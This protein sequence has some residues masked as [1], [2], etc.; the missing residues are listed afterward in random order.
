MKMSIA[1]PVNDPALQWLLGKDNLLLGCHIVLPIPL[2]N[3][4]W[5][6]VL[7]V[8]YVYRWYTYLIRIKYLG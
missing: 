7:Y 8:D 3:V 2:K 5:Y 4:Y 6:T 1:M